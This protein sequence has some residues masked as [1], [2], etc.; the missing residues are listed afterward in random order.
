MSSSSRRNPGI[1]AE[2]ASAIPAPPAPFLPRAEL[3]P[4]GHRLYRV[5]SSVRTVAEFN[6]GH[7]SRTRFA[8]FGDPVV[9]VLYAADTAEAALAESLLHDVPAAGGLLPYSAYRDKVMGLVEVR[10]R[11]RLASL[12]GLGLRRLGIEARHVTDTAASEYPRT[13]AWAQAAHAAGF[14]GVAW[15]SRK[16]NDARAVVLFGDRCAGALRQDPSFGRMFQS[17]PGLDWLIEVCS[18][19]RVDVLPPSGR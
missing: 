7:G 4:R 5:H 12:R 10:R 19:L 14:D 6:P 17:G 3:L 1:G 18:P 2:D 9:P 11:L 16:C 8:F 15:T 13:V